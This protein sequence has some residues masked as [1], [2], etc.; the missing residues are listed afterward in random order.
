MVKNRNYDDEK[1]KQRNHDGEKSILFRVFTTVVS[2][3]HHSG[4]VVS[5]SRHRSFVFSLF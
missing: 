2:N 3:F 4:F 5:A 1:S